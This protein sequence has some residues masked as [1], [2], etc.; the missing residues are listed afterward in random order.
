MPL[1]D[2]ITYGEGSSQGGGYRLPLWNALRAQGAP[3][4]FVG[5]MHTGP[6]GFARD[7]EGHP[8]WKVDQIAGR[9]VNW[10][11]KYRPQIILLHIGTNDVLRQD[12]L[13][14]APARLRR[15]VDLITSTAPEATLIV[16]QII[17]LGRGPRLDADVLNYNRAIPDLVR[18]EVADGRNVRYIDMYHSISSTLLPDGIH[19]NDQAYTLMARAWE[20][21]LLPLLHLSH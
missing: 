1:G 21:A 15:L 2:S 10:L 18:A 17:P 11:R 3:I 9:V 19:P 6:T 14:R 8:G 12:D 7:N 5:S 20:Q 16:A 13:A 4:T